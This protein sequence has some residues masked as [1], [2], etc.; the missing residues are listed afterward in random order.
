MSKES[1]SLE[2]MLEQWPELGEEEL[3]VEVGPLSPIVSESKKE[4]LPL[5]CIHC[6]WVSMSYDR[7]PSKAR[8]FAPR[9]YA[10]INVID[11]SKVY[12]Y[13]LC[14]EQRDSRNRHP[15]ACQLAGLHFKERTAKAIIS[16]SIIE[17]EEFS[18]R[19]AKKDM[20]KPKLKKL[21]KLSD[22]DLD[23]I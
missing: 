4:N 20:P 23:E 1:Y 3:T 18:E 19:L 13:P 15:E 9:N 11:G 16:A 5:L 22:S 10:G 2:E 6:E 8:C 7:E 21:P 12:R 17:P 14:M